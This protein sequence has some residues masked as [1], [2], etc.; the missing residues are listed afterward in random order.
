VSGAPSTAWSGF[1][2]GRYVPG[3]AHSYFEGSESE[4]LDLA[5]A[6]W[7]K[8]RPG[9]GRTD[10]SKVVVVPVPA[11]RFVCGTVLVDES[12]RLEARFTRRQAHEDGYV[13]LSADG[14]R[15]PARHAAVVFYS[16]ATL[17]E[18]GG[19]RSSDA[20]WELV[21]VIASPVADEPMDPLT[22][23]RNML[24]ESGGTPCD[25]TAQQFAES[26][27]YWASRAAVLPDD[28]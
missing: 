28:D 12:T 17:L 21:C 5:A 7:S 16:A 3:G 27:W 1:A 18:N 24:A 23:A 15:E 10:L 22:M 26:V 9:A 8:R 6:H 20:D 13:E 11:D 19:E 4:L 2:R 25:Y 14:P